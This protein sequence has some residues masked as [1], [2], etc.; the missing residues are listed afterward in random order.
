MKKD[1]IKVYIYTRVSTTIQVDGYS[2]DAQKARIK[3]FAEYNDYKI[4]GEYEDAGKSGKSIEGRLEFNRMMEDIKS[5][6]D[7]VSYVLVFKLSR[8]GRN[9]ADVLSTLQVMQ[10][11]GVN[12]ICVEDGIDSSKDAG[13][14]MISVLSAVAEIERENIRVQTMEGRIQK[15]R[16]G[17]WNGGFAPYG[18]TLEKGKLYVNEEEAEAIRIIFDKYVHTDMGANGLARYLAN[19]GI[20]KIQR[21]NGKNPLFDAALIRRILKNPVYCGK[22]AYGRRRTEKVHGTR[23]DYRLIE[24]DNYL[25]VDGLHEALVSEE[26]WHD[27]QVKL[28]A[29][30]KKYEK[31]NHG[32]DNKVHLLTGLLKCP[33]CGAGMY[34]NKSVKHK[35]DGTK[36]KDFYYYGCKH[37]TMTRGHKCDY[38][39]QIHEELLETA[40]AEVITKLVSNPKFAALMQQKISMK[41]DTSAIEQEIANYEKQLRQSYSIKSRLI[42][43]IDTLD[44]DDK[45]YIKRK[46][47][48]DDRLYKMYDKIEDTESLLIEARAKK[49]A[50]EAEKLTADNIYKVLIYFDK[51]YAVMDEQE[52]RQLMESLISEIHIF[53][54]RKPNGQWLKSI[55]FKLPIIEENMG[56]V[57]HIVKRFLNRGYDAEELFQIGCI[58]LMKAVDHFDTGYDVKFSTYAVPMIMGEIKRFLR[59]NGMI[60]VSRSLKENAW[61]IRQTRTML[62]AKLGREPAVDEIAAQME[63]SVEEIIQAMEADVEV[64]SLSRTV[65]QGDGNEICLYEKLAD[66]R[67][68]MQQLVN[69]VFLQDL[70]Q[71]LPGEEQN[72]I[73]YR[74]YDNL[75]QVETA[76]RM[77]I[78]QVQVSRLEKKI[79]REM[80]EMAG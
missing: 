52:R 2:L 43:E 30:A 50:I 36:Y 22:I 7:G 23:N 71:K 74:Y 10:D 65:Y 64:E 9:A 62:E 59:D 42:E 78:S 1:K 38:K 68:D 55:K 54:E 34:G 31:V 39:K 35:A 17:K 47:D 33:I 58:G 61:R 16:E 25:L 27:A 4:V 49:M 40:V 72:L 15:A 13:K 21:Q 69:H 51:L 5:G 37:R 11:F 66:E 77:G 63:L 3:A 46:A 53:E 6:K 32:K 75:T 76:K 20:G 14:L 67:D 79:L 70:L 41:V 24:Q 44:P 56:L 48:L 19:H 28:V 8:F 26:L 73:R 80:R 29:Q 45:H 60:K 18:Y 57:H 12:L